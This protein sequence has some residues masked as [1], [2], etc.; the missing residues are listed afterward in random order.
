M[1]KVFYENPRQIY[2]L[3]NSPIIPNIPEIYFQVSHQCPMEQNWPISK[4]PE[5]GGGGEIRTLDTLACITV[6]ETAPFNR[7]G[8]PPTHGT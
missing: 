7:S 3:E 6:F 2:V 5:S 4:Y 1:L 8:T